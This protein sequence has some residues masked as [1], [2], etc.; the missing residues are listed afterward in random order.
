MTSISIVATMCF[1][2]DHDQA[3][4][5]VPM[6]T[7][8]KRH[9]RAHNVFF[10]RA[11]AW[12][13]PKIHNSGHLQVQ[14]NVLSKRNVTWIFVN[15]IHECK[16]RWGD[17]ES[18]LKNEDW[19]WD[20]QKRLLKR[21]FLCKG[22]EVTE[23]VASSNTEWSKSHWAVRKNKLL[24]VTSWMHIQLVDPKGVGYFCNKRRKWAP[25]VSEH[26]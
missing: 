21:M 20:Y 17:L 7:A 25:L 24:I 11:R 9:G 19:L 5:L 14:N 23:C 16:Y 10:P 15:F 3:G 26:F 22:D 13:T 2:N 12:R 18:Y 8:T 6:K 4:C 1:N